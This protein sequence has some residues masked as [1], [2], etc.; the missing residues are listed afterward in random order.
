MVLVT[1]KAGFDALKGRSEMSDAGFAM[2][3]GKFDGT[4]TD[5]EASGTILDALKGKSGALDG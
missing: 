5:F 2:S 4:E 1:S 3:N